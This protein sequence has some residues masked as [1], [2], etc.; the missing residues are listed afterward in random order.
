MKRLDPFATGVF[1]GWPVA[2]VIA[3][4]LVGPLGAVVVFVGWLPTVVTVGYLVEGRRDRHLGARRRVVVR[5]ARPGALS[6][7]G[8][9]VRG[10]WPPRAIQ[11]MPIAPLDDPD[12]GKR[13]DA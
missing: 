10:P 9:V 11:T 6:R 3:W 2:A 12:G 13:A 7:R 8:V 1:V 4:S 5:S